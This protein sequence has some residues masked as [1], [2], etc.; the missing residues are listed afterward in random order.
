MAVQSTPL[1]VQAGSHPAEDMRRLVHGIFGGRGGI[2]KS[3][4]LTVTQHAGTANMSV[5]VAEGRVI[6]PGTEATYQGV[7]YGEARGVTNLAISAANATNPRIDLVVARIRDAAY[8]TGPSSS[9]AL[10]VLTGT[11]AASP[12]EPAVPANCWVLARVYVAAAV[13]SIL[14]AAITDYR[15]TFSGK[16]RAAVGITVTTAAAF[17]TVNV[18]VGAMGYATDTK[19]L[20]AWNGAGW[21]LVASAPTSWTAP[22]LLSSWANFAGYTPA[23]YRKVGDI[24][25][26]RGSLQKATTPT[27]GENI[28]VL[29]SG[30]RPPY[31]GFYSAQGANEVAYRI[32]LAT[33]GSVRFAAAPS[34]PIAFLS[35]ANIYFSTTA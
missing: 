17:P 10:E 5:D 4:D 32:D 1:W 22:T 28:L 2:M 11:A 25:Y 9:F 15:L 3:T 20:Y 19:E 18:D 7:Y 31:A 35:L 16:G 24:V 6:I 33:D 23:G 30:Y 14:N 21:T 26:L 13:T 29:P 12:V 27:A 8:S 34:G